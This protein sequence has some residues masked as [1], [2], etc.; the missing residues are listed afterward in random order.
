MTA[1]FDESARAFDAAREFAEK[2]AQLEP[3]NADHRRRVLQS[4]TFGS[5]LLLQSNRGAGVE[6]IQ[7]VLDLAREIGGAPDAPFASRFELGFS[8]NM[9]GTFAMNA[10]R[11]P[12]AARHFREAS[13]ILREL[14][15]KAA[16]T[17]REAERLLQTRAMSA[18]QLGL[19]EAI[20]TRDPD[21]GRR[22]AADLRQA[23]AILDGLLAIQPGTATHKILKIQGLSVLAQLDRAFAPRAEYRATV[24]SLRAV[25]DAITEGRPA[26]EWVRK[27]GVNVFAVAAVEDARAGRPDAVVEAERLL[28]I[29][30]SPALFPA[31][32]PQM[33]L[34]KYN[35]A[36]VFALAGAK[37]DDSVRRVEL[38][39]RA[40]KLLDELKADRYF[41]N[42]NN[43]RALATDADLAP[44]RD[45]DDWRRLVVAVSKEFLV[46]VRANV[47]ANGAELANALANIGKTLVDHGEFAE[48][49]PLLREGL[50]IREKLAPNEWSTFN[51]R[52]LLGAALAGLSKPGDA[53]PLMKAGYEGLVR[54]RDSIPAT[55]PRILFDAG[56]RLASL[57][58][59]TN[60]PEL[61]AVLRATLPREPAPTPKE[62]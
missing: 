26:F 56:H 18:I 10:G 36:C 38:A 23:I 29:V 31:G 24:K 19:V 35:A 33:L 32:A 51:A 7:P 15:S 28:R 16:P 9:A 3:A 50:A 17:A 62:K 8:L 37:A 54:T 61:A 48:A 13:A 30:G 39:D 12:L 5:Y 27:V 21:E 6:Q 59:A 57:Y 55:S 58:A 53:E 40:M 22:I 46:I 2:A 43:A 45:R 52:S 14:D 11:F 4:R 41:R 25:E 44:L 1:R 20:Q 49:E 47:P 34:V 60:R 42:P